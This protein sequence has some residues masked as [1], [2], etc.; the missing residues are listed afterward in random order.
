[1]TVMDSQRSKVVRLN[2]HRHQH[3]EVHWVC[4]PLKM[5]SSLTLSVCGR[6]RR[7]WRKRRSDSMRNKASY[8]SLVQS[9]EIS[10][11]QPLWACRLDRQLLVEA[12]SLS[13]GSCFA[14]LFMQNWLDCLCLCCGASVV[15]F[16]FVLVSRFFSSP[17]GTLGW[18]RI[19]FFFP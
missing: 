15:V 3:A 14:K 18:G 16:L 7:T 8:F 11:T 6:W 17:G 2:F 19:F 9:I 13:H 10:N 4:T 12:C 1:M 5:C